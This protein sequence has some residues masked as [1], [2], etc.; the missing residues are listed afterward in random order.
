MVNSLNKKKKSSDIKIKMAKINLTRNRNPKSKRKRI[1]DISISN[2]FYELNIYGPNKNWKRIR[3]FE[4]AFIDIPGKMFA[5]PSKEKEVLDFLRYC[6]YVLDVP[7]KTLSVVKVDGKFYGS[8]SGENFFNHNKE[9]VIWFRMMAPVNFDECD[10]LA[11]R[12]LLTMV[13]ERDLSLGDKILVRDIAI[14]S[15]HRTLEAAADLNV[16]EGYSFEMCVRTDLQEY[17]LNR[18]NVYGF[19]T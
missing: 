16:A 8:T 17:A 18:L 5:T 14:D 10:P 19:K 11:F 2:P 4:D 12:N 3:A 1:Y 9:D 13:E 6:P 7:K 15:F